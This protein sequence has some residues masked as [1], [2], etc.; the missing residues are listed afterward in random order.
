M[1]VEHA[2]PPTISVSLQAAP[3]RFLN[4]GTSQQVDIGTSTRPMAFNPL[5]V[6][7]EDCVTDQTLEFLLTG[8]GFNGR[9]SSRS[10]PARRPIAR[11]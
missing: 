1:R 2:G 10:G 7:Y 6:N 5:G 11:R 8:C 9:R 4:F 3:E